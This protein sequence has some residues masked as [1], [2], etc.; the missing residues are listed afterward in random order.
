VLVRRNQTSL[1]E[2]GSH[3]D[4]GVGSNPNLDRT[5]NF[6]WGCLQILSRVILVW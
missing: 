4:S 2:L 6:L 5:R 3:F 1:E